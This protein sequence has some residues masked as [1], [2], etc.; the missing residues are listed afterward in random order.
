MDRDGAVLPWYDLRRARTRLQLSLLLGVLGALSVRTALPLRIAVIGGWDVAAL[1]LLL[2]SWW[3]IARGDADDAKRRAGAEDPGRRVL[4][5]LS[6][7]SSLISFFAAAL[8]IHQTDEQ[9][10]LRE[11]AVGICLAAPVLA[12]LLTHSVY[13][14][15]YAHLYYRA[16]EEGSGLSFPGDE[17]PDDMDFAYFAFTVGMCF[18]TS[19]VEITSKRLRRSV[20]LHALLSFVFNT[21]VIALALNLALGKLL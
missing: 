16:H 8:V 9:D 12:W 3:I 1:T 21:A 5:L 2:S 6:L 19:D 10:R 17:A 7:V 4:L 14:L 13:T 18:Q 11:L 20:L 15:H